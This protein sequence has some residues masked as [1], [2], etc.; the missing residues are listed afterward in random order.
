MKPNYN[1]LPS[2]FFGYG[3]GRLCDH[4]GSRC[5]V[6]FPRPE[7]PLVSQPFC[8]EFFRS[9]MEA[10]YKISREA[11][12]AIIDNGHSGLGG[13]DVFVNRQRACNNAHATIVYYIDEE[14]DNISVEYLK[15]YANNCC[16]GW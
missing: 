1:D 3:K 12:D 14:I 6:E 2:E 4:R 7:P 9:E 13:V 11:L 5:D 15:T 8:V 10:T 16:N